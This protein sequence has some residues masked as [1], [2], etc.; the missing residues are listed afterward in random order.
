MDTDS[1]LVPLA[2]VFGAS[3]LLFAYLSLA[4]HAA[5][6][7]NGHA[8]GT[9]QHNLSFVASSFKNACI[10]AAALS[11]LALALS[12]QT[13]GWWWAAVLAVTLLAIL[14]VINRCIYVA[15]S[16]SPFKSRQFSAPLQR[17]L[18]KESQRRTSNGSSEIDDDADIELEKR[19]IA[20]ADSVKV[21]ERDREMLRS[22]LRLDVS[23]VREIMVPRLDMVTRPSLPPYSSTTMAI[24]RA[25]CCSSSNKSSNRLDSG[26]KNAG[27]IAS[28][29][30]VSPG[31]KTRK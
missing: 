21:D 9:P 11:G 17:W 31:P 25:L 30:D 15:A 14:A 29:K 10:I 3:L 2:L 26:T 19:V 5:S 27:L 1:S 8:N 16:R 28:C 23:T 6:V 12:I 13:L 18:F 24:C 20:A 4:E 7:G 22:I